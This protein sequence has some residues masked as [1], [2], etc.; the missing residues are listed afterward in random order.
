MTDY[1][2]KCALCDDLIHD[3]HG[4][5][6]PQPLDR[7]EDERCCGVC[8]SRIVLAARFY[9]VSKGRSPY[10][11]MPAEEVDHFRRIALL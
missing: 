3:V 1:P 4:S 8:N 2:I 7:S 10:A 5:H 11:D 6:N 9:N